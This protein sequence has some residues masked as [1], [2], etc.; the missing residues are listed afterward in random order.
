MSKALTCAI[1][2]LFSG[3]LSMPA[4][5]ETQSITGERLV[6]EI[7]VDN[8]PL[9]KF[10]E[11][12]IY[13]QDLSGV[14]VEGADVVIDGGMRAHGH[15][16]PTSPVVEEIGGGAYQIKGL[17]FSMPGMWEIVFDMIKQGISEKIAVEFQVY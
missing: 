16:L 1:C 4:D 7:D 2:V 9:R 15:G 13:I 10:I 3:L 8:L 14:G 5:A 6:I 11:L 17:K 12:P